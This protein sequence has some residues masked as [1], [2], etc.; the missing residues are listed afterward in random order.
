MIDATIVSGL[1]AYEDYK[2]FNDIR[3][4]FLECSADVKTTIDG[5][6]QERIEMRSQRSLPSR[7]SG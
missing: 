7:S 6:T 2:Y 5:L 1:S 3:E 4:S